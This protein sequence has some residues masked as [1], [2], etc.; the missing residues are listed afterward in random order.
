MPVKTPTKEQQLECVRAWGRAG[1]AMEELRIQELRDMS[2][3]D[4]VRLFNAL[5]CPPPTEWTKS[6]GL[7]EQQRLFSKLTHSA[8]DESRF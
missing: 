8:A 6:S 1:R 5:D 3:E 7:V 4:S 2:E